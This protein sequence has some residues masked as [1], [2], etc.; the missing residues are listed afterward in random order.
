MKTAS[1]IIETIGRDAIL[2]TFGVK[3]RVLRHYGT[4]GQ[5]PASWFDALERMAGRELPRHLFSFKGL[6]Q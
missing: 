1:D 2:R 6:G 5:L 3:P 4:T